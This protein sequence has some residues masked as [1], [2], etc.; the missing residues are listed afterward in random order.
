LAMP[1]TWPGIISSKPIT[2]SSAST[3][4]IIVA[5]S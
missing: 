5:I 3:E 1:K 4:M 2:W